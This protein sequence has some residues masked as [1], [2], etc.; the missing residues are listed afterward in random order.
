MKY[1]LINRGN[2][3]LP[4]WA[5]SVQAQ[6][7]AL[8]AGPRE[9][10]KLFR[11]CSVVC[12]R[13]GDRLAQVMGTDPA[14]VVTRSHLS[15]LEH[16]HSQAMADALTEPREDDPAAQL[17]H[18]HRIVDTHTL[19]ARHSR[20]S[21]THSWWQAV[22]RLPEA[23]AADW[24]RFD[25]TCKCRSVPITRAEFRQLVEGLRKVVL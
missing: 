23:G 3:P 19:A 21:S 25:L 12:S 7:M 20:V 5:A 10:W 16:P 18:L 9:R 24:E 11:R 2:A 1:Q 6:L 8:D 22:D 17:E 14:V 13:C 15:S 4:E